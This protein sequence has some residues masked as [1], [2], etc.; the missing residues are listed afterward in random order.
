VHE[1]CVIAVPDDKRGENVMA[2]LVLK[3]AFQGQIT[4]QD[5]IDWSR[6]HMAAYKTPRI[7]RFVDTL[8][9]SGTGKIL[10]RQLQEQERARLAAIHAMNQAS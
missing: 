4:E 2:L 10:W 7:V 6:E 5:V 1:A 9:K 8:P 3:P